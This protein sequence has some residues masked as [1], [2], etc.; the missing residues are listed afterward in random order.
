MDQVQSADEY[1]G[2]AQEEEV[3]L[4]YEAPGVPDEHKDAGGHDDAEHLSEAVKKEV[5]VQTRQ[6][7]ADEGQHTQGN[8]DDRTRNDR[9][10]CG[11]VRY[12]ALA[13]QRK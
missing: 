1:V 4:V 12:C 2:D 3:T 10:L 8:G 13:D 7:Q 5:T 11:H 9:A 6:V